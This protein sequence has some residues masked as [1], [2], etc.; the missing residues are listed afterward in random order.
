MRYR[1][2][3]AE[4]DDDQQSRSNRYLFV[5]SNQRQEIFMTLTNLRRDTEYSVQASVGFQYI[6]SLCFGYIEGPLSQAFTFRTNA[7][8]ECFVSETI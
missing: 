8:S 1:L 2:S 5:G 4:V 3:Y 7:T 6:F